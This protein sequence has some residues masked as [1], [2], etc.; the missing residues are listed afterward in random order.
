MKLYHAPTSPYV[1]KVMV[2][3]HET[4]QAGDVEIVSVSTTPVST[5]AG[6]AAENPLGK[7]PCLITDAGEA[8]YDS[9][10]ICAFLGEPHGLY[11][12]DRAT[13]LR[14]FEAMCDGVLDAAILCVYEKRLRE[15]GQRSDAWV[16]GQMAKVTRALD[17]AEARHAALLGADL[18][19]GHVA[20]GCMLGYL[21]LRFPDLGWRD[22]HPGLAAWYE[23]FSQRP[24]MTATVPPAA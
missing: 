23:T 7:I 22:G 1:R 24:S 8:V 6:L 20:L 3:L 15:E 21:D 11:P 10:V 2:V 16:A 5:D 9:R 12:A 17:A 19:I 4:G 13:A 14:T 18:T